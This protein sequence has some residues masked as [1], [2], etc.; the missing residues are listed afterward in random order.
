[1]KVKYFVKTSCA[2][3]QRPTLAKQST[4]LQHDQ[5]THTAALCKSSA[6]S[7]QGEITVHSLFHFKNPLPVQS[8][9]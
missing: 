7:G 4:D 9:G 1:M 2:I 5:P 8:C 3:I 6:N